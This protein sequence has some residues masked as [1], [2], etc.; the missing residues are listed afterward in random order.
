MAFLEMVGIM[1]FRWPP[2]LRVWINLLMCVNV[3]GVCLFPHRLESQV[4]IGC[5]LLSGS[6]MSY[7]YQYR[8]GFTKLL[9]VGHAPWIPMLAWIALWRLPLLVDEEDSAFR[10][11]LVALLL[12]DGISVLLDVR[13]VYRYF[14]L[15]KTEPTMVW[16]D[17]KTKAT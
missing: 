10:T 7:L 13:D 17:T 16:A 4:S 2:A 12:F 14:M 6:I 9:G 15:G 3:A 11:Y 5:M 1:M 8:G